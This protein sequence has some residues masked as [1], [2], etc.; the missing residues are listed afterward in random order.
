[1][2]NEHWETL[3][4]PL[5]DTIQ[6]LF[7]HYTYYNPSLEPT[8]T[9]Y[10]PISSLEVSTVSVNLKSGVWKYF[11]KATVDGARMAQ[12]KLLCFICFSQKYG[13]LLPCRYIKSNYPEH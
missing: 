12:C 4:W 2:S 5:T 3:N 6:I 13:N 10:M 1:M 9:P 7:M 8:A 11:D